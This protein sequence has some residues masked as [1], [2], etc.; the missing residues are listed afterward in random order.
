MCFLNSYLWLFRVRQ[1]IICYLLSHVLSCPIVDLKL[2]ILRSLR[3][4]SDRIKLQMLLPVITELQISDKETDSDEADQLHELMLCSFDSSTAKDL[5]SE[6]DIRPWTTFVH[7]LK[8][9]LKLSRTSRQWKVLANNMRN[10]LFAA[11]TLNK[12]TDICLLVLRYG[13]VQEESVSE[14][15]SHL[16]VTFTSFVDFW[17]QGPSERFPQTVVHYKCPF[18]LLSARH[19]TRAREGC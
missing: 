16:E 5:C 8:A 10:G 6:E 1:R 12:K 13:T 15:F 9:C 11:L 7:V 18:T 17:N 4:V 19:W 2:A 14:N 3:K